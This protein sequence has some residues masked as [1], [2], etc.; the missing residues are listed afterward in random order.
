MTF[1]TGS[2]GGKYSITD[3]PKHKHSYYWPNFISA[4]SGSGG[5]GFVYNGS[6]STWDDGFETGSSKVSVQNPYYV[7]YRWRRTA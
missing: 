4:S 7:T 3:V 6:T 1:T 2:T 5:N